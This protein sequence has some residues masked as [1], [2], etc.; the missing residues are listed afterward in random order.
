MNRHGFY[1]TPTAA[2]PNH[3]ASDLEEGELEDGDIEES[4]AAIAEKVPN[5][6]DSTVGKVS[7]H[8]R[9]QV[10]SSLANPYDRQSQLRSPNNRIL[11]VIIPRDN[12]RACLVFLAQCLLEVRR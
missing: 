12:R 4:K 11:Q 6:N 10:Y 3:T 1:E 8:V 9:T 7:I 5:N 2:Q